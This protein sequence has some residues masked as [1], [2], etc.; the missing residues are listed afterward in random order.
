MGLDTATVN[1]ATGAIRAMD[2]IKATDVKATEVKATA[3]DQATVSP[4]MG[5]N[6]A[7]EDILNPATDNP[8]DMAPTAR[9]TTEELSNKQANKRGFVLSSLAIRNIMPRTDHTI[10]KIRVY[11]FSFLMDICI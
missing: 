3:A 5:T 2:V 6:L 4:D 7:T 8:R 1:R 10:I 11:D 9:N